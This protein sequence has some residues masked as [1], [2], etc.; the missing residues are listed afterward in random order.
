MCLDSIKIFK[1]KLNIPIGLSDHSG[2]IFPAVYA[3]AHKAN[4]IEVHLCMDKNQYGPDTSSSLTPSELSLVTN[5]RDSFSIFEKKVNRDLV[6]KSIKH[7]ELFT[8]LIALKSD[9]NKGYILKKNLIS[10]SRNQEL[11]SHLKNWE[12]NWEKLI[13]NV[14]KKKLLRY[15]DIK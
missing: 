4:L 12:S 15:D 10:L 13:K 8:R 11:E 3:L 5:F 1:D 9:K 6:V 14:S 2:T 7:K